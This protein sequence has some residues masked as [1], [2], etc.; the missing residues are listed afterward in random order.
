M[1]AT[2]ARSPVETFLARLDR[3]E[4]VPHSLMH[5]NGTR[6]CGIPVRRLSLVLG[7]ATLT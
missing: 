1:H 7:L 6:G 2:F 5:A 4:I 3:A